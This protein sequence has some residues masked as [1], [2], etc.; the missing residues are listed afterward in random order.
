M[1]PKAKKGSQ[2]QDEEAK[3]QQEKE[4]KKAAATA[5]RKEKEMVKK[6]AEEGASKEAKGDMSNFITQGKAALK[7]LE[8]GGELSEQSKELASMYK[9]Y[10][11]LPVRSE[12]KTEIVGNWK[13]DRTCS[14]TNSFIETHTTIDKEKTVEKEGWCTSWAIA[15]ELNMPHDSL[16]FQAILEFY[17]KAGPEVWDESNPAQLPF[18]KAGLPGYFYVGQSMK[19][20][21]HEEGYGESF[22]S[23]SEAKKAKHS[24]GDLAKGSVDS[25]VTLKIEHEPFHNSAAVVKTIEKH[26]GLYTEVMNQ[27]KNLKVELMALPNVEM[28]ETNLAR[29]DKCMA[30]VDKEE[31][32]SMTLCSQFSNIARDDD[33]GHL[34]FYPKLEVSL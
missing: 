7:K 24:I 2:V 5:K 30:Q 33:Q 10:R 18:K 12:L 15:K 29:V 8:E 32:A 26:L 17:K 6:A 23:S 31:I 27:F 21:V 13:K 22:A 3:K 11:E 9:Y 20:K 1:A 25:P 16:E 14:W 4:E 34:N 28:H 19:E